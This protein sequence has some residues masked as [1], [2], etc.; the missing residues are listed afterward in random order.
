M[1]PIK[2]RLEC[3]CC[4]R[5]FEVTYDADVPTRIL[6]LQCKCG[7]VTSVR[8]VP[9][10]RISNERLRNTREWA[11]ARIGQLSGAEVIVGAIDE[12]IARRQADQPKA[13]L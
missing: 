8:Q 10:L 9:E 5:G 13:D 4:R 7:H 12:L 2:S 6:E 3:G 1:T 11:A